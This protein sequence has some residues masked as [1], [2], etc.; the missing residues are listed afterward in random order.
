MDSR[1]LEVADWEEAVELYHRNGWT[2]GLPIVPPTA[3]RLA[4]FA[5]AAQRPLSEEIG[6]YALRDR[7]VTVEK[8]AINSI[9]AGCL[10]EHLPVVI[11]LVECM[12]EPAFD[13]HTASSSTGSLALGFV[14]NG[15]IRHTL[16]MNCHGNVL[17]PGNRANASIGRALRLIQLNVLGSVGGSGTTPADGRPV[18]D[19][20][21][22]GQPA[23]YVAYHI[24]ENEEAFPELVPLHVMRGFDPLDSVVSAFAVGA[25]I[26]LSNHAE[27]SPEDW[28]ASV[29]HYLV[30]AGRLAEGGF[31]I[32]LVPPEPAAMF[33]RAGWSKADISRALYERGRRSTAWVKENGWKI[34][35]RFERGGAVESGDNETT[36]NVAGSAEDIHVVVCGGPAGNFPVYIQTYAS[37]FEIVSRK[38]RPASNGGLA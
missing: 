18:L 32:L 33:V 7:P 17:G 20:S 21:T 11:A 3:A 24:V 13:I 35:G 22:M 2:D 5:D 12:L 6:Y 30:G 26:M 31:G 29:A 27:E 1:L 10:P 37:S 8:V 28:I 9:M 19:R 36:L 25:H 23:K 15:P 14:V 16:D 4:A 34:G 38:I